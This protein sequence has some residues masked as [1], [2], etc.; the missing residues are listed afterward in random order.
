M[1]LVEG[2]TVT[3]KKLKFGEIG[4]WSALK[5]EII[6]NYAAEYSKIL[7]LRIKQRNR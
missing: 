3:A 5:L 1:T 7:V 2:D 4:A 6:Q